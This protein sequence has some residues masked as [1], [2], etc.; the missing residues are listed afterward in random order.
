MWFD[1][2]NEDVVF[3]DKRIHTS[4]YIKQQPNFSIIPSVQCDFRYLPFKDCS[5]HL[6]SFDPP[7]ITDVS[8]FSI[9]GKKYGTINSNTWESDLKMGVD[10][11]FRCLKP[12]GTL[13]FKWN[14]A[15]ISIKDVISA[16]GRSPMFGHT[17]AKSGKTKWMCF[18][19]EAY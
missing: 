15:R 14:E 19:K 7:H 5:F 16:I 17:T 8:L 6:I 11:C 18:M 2:K 13:V 1:K 10:E 3:C 12:N 4:G 9:M